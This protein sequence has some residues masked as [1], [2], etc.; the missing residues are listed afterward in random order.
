MNNDYLINKCL[1]TGILTDQ[2]IRKYC[3]YPANLAVVLKAYALEACLPYDMDYTDLDEHKLYLTDDGLAWLYSVFRNYSLQFLRRAFQF[4]F[5]KAT[6]EDLDKLE[7][8]EGCKNF[9]GETGPKVKVGMKRGALL[10]RKVG[11][12]ERK[13]EYDTLAEARQAVLDL[14]R[15][16]PADQFTLYRMKRTVRKG[17]ENFYRQKVPLILEQSKRGLAGREALSKYYGRDTNDT[18][19][20]VSKE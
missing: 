19:R 13:Y 10:I 8:Y 11:R 5:T 20:S 16:F 2:P 4:V 7:Q 1:T 15:F 9:R 6:E 14:T 18:T 3:L 17:K 12:V